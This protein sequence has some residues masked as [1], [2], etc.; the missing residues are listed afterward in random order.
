MI[1]RTQLGRLAVAAAAIALVVGAAEAA[2]A[3]GQETDPPPGG[4]IRH[5]TIDG[6]RR[7]ALVFAPRATRGTKP[8]LVIAFHGH[9]GDSRTTAA[10]MRIH[11]LWPQAVVVY[12]QGLNTPTV[13]DPAGTR[14]GWQ[15]QGG[16]LGDRDLE[17]VDA[18]V[19]TMKRSHAVDRRRI[20][21][22]G[23]SNGAVFSLLLWAE[24]AHV[25]AAIGEV[26]GRL[27][28]SATP[29]SPRA[30]LAVVGRSDRVAPFALQRQT[31]RQ[32]R[33]INGALGPGSTCGRYCTLYA[34]T[35]GPTPVKT[36]VHPGGHV[37][38]TWASTELVRFFRSHRQ[39]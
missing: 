25:I 27:H 16:E 29:T 37:Y 35:S 4:T 13:H 9:G 32:A 14:S 18:I 24:R 10:R 2:T 28:P 8:P 22:T 15:G 21:A 11:T 36:L 39:P 30:L 1:A 5:W 23:F 3:G 19:A 38:P 7:Q 17:L 33:V 31:I 6:V 34:S 12:P 26:A 20:Y